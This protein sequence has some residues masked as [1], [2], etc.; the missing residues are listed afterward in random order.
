METNHNKKVQS[1]GKRMVL[2]R[3][4]ER[5]RVRVLKAIENESEDKRSKAHF[6]VS[7]RKRIKE[8]KTCGMGTKL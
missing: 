8:W 6:L 2:E 3:N 7:S 4:G 1:K 5:Y